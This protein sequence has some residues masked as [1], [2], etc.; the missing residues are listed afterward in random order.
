[1]LIDIWYRD[2]VTIKFAGGSQHE[3]PTLSLPGIPRVGDDIT[4]DSGTT[5]KV[6]RVL[7]DVTSRGLRDILV[8]LEPQK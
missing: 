6:T 3:P 2:T 8:C 4:L 5:Y 7:W 1:M